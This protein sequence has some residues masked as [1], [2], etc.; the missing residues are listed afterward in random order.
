MDRLLYEIYTRG[1]YRE[2]TTQSMSYTLLIR[3]CGLDISVLFS[4]LRDQCFM[5]INCLA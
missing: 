2:A 1:M 3:P 4:D 5:S